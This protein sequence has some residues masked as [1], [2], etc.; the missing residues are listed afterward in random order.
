MSAPDPTTARDLLAQA[1]KASAAAA[2]GAS[3][4]WTVALMGLGGAS[5]IGLIALWLDARA[6]G[7]HTLLVLIP[8]LAWIGLS[9][10]FGTTF[11]RAAKV[12]FG[13]RW[14]VTMGAW[15]VAWIA[16]VLA[17]TSL[18]DQVWVPA[19]AAGV[20]LAITGAGAWAET[21]R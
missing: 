18:T 10:L 4:P 14:D 15:A 20:L 1:D 5:S 9:I 13:R 8:V 6:G 12:G 21:R 7:S 16:G 17:V 3:W 11:G 2:S 19:T